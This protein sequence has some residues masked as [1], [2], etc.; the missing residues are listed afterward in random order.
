MISIT[1]VAVHAG[2]SGVA[3]TL[4]GIAAVAMLT[5]GQ[6]HTLRAVPAKPANL[7]GARVRGGALA[8]DARWAAH[9]GGAELVLVAPTRQA[10]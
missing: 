9:G 10:P 8:V 3:V 7:A 6:A 4:E 2:P 1:L 5:V